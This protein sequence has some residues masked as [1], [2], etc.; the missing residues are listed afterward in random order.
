MKSLF[1]HG[2]ASL[3]LS[4]AVS[5]ALVVALYHQIALH[6]LPCALCWLQRFAMM[7]ILVAQ[8]YLLVKLGRDKPISATEISAV[9]GLSITA[10]LVGLS[11]SL[12]QVFLHILPGDPGYGGEVMGMHFY[13]WA[14]VLFFA[15][16]VGSGLTLALSRWL[17][18]EAGVWRVPAKLTVW[19]ILGVVVVNAVL[20]FA[21]QG[22]QW[23]LDGDPT[24]YRLFQSAP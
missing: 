14:F 22:F 11:L 18:T 15:C 10:A 6:D 8:S 12:R 5:A 19:L 3:L 21:M 2:L 7:A 20:V 17:H 9:H 24:H 4:W 1:S 23:E 16:L 13:T